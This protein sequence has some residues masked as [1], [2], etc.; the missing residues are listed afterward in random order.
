MMFV[1]RVY[2]AIVMVIVM[3]LRKKMYTKYKLEAAKRQLETTK[4]HPVVLVQIPM[5]NEK[6]VHPG[7]ISNQ[8]DAI[9][10]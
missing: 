5:Y 10:I 2:M 8:I 7:W 6:E 1:E 3:L 9:T 4:N